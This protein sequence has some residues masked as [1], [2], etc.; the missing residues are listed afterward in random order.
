ML[1]LHYKD[2]ADG[3]QRGITQMCIGNLNIIH[4]PLGSMNSFIKK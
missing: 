2:G 3:S 1:G 4:L